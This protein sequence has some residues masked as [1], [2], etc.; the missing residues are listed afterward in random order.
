[1]S[2]A[3]LN[4]LFLFG[5]TAGILPILIHRLTEKKAIPKKFSAVRLLLES[6]KVMAKPQRLKHL[7]LLALRV[8]AVMIL[9]LMMARPVMTRQSLLSPADSGAKI[10]ILDNSLSMGYRE[11]RGER[12]ELAK[13][14]AKEVL[15]GLR[16]QVLI[17]PTAPSQGRPAERNEARWMSPQEAIKEMSAIPL[18]FGRGTRLLPW[19]RHIGN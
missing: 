4:P 5:L 13:R 10:L 12:Y 6:Q 2:L 3:F 17:I 19:S 8:L 1:M 9:V 14:A 15:E 11:E 16:G 7:L 18:S